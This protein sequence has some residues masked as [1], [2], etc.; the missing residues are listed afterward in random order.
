MYSHAPI[1]IEKWVLNIFASGSPHSRI[2]FSMVPWLNLL[3]VT[4]TRILHVSCPTTGSESYG[5][6]PGNNKANDRHIFQYFVWSQQGVKLKLHEPSWESS[7][8]LVAYQP[9]FVLTA[10]DLEEF[11]SCKA[12]RI[13]LRYEEL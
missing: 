1:E 8:V 9:P 7:S 10:S 13:F 12:V 2:L 4:A 6:Q 3:L 11:I 5:F